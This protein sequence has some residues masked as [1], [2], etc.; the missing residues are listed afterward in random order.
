METPRDRSYRHTSHNSAS[1]K[2][3]GIS[4][5]AYG[6]LD[7]ATP[8]RSVSSHTHGSRKRKVGVP[9][10]REDGLYAQ[11]SH[12]EVEAELPVLTSS[13]SQAAFGNDIPNLVLS[14][15]D[16]TERT[17]VAA[18]DQS[19]MS[20]SAQG[21]GETGKKKRRRK[22]KI[23]FSS[24]D[25]S[26]NVRDDKSF[27]VNPTS[28]GGMTESQ[29]LTEDSDQTHTALFQKSTHGNDAVVSYEADRTVSSVGEV[30]SDLTLAM[31]PADVSMA[32]QTPT[33]A[34]RVLPLSERL[35]RRR[36]KKRKLI[37]SSPPLPRSDD[38]FAS[39]TPTR[40]RRSL[41]DVYENGMSPEKTSAQESDQGRTAETKPSEPASEKGTKT[42]RRKRRQP[43]ESDSTV[44]SRSQQEDADVDFA[45]PKKRK[46]SGS[47]RSHAANTLE[48]QVD[49]SLVSADAQIK[50]ITTTTPVP[51]ADNLTTLSPGRVQSLGERVTA[52]YH[53]ESVGSVSNDYD[54]QNEDSG[55]SPVT[56]AIVDASKDGEDAFPV[57][58]ENVDAV[59][60]SNSQLLPSDNGIHSPAKRA[61]PR[62][63]RSMLGIDGYD[64][65][66][67]TPKKTRKRAKTPGTAGNDDSIVFGSQHSVTMTTFDSILAANSPPR[68]LES[69]EVSSR[70][71]G[72]KAPTDFCVPESQSLD[73]R[74]PTVS[75]EHFVPESVG[76]DSQV[77][78]VSSNFCVPE[79]ES[80]D[81]QGA[82]GYLPTP[83]PGDLPD[84][85]SEAPSLFAAGGDQADITGTRV[86]SYGD[87]NH[88]SMKIKSPLKKPH[89]FTKKP[90]AVVGKN[91]SKSGMP[92]Q[93]A[94]LDS[95]GS[96][97][98]T[99]DEIVAGSEDDSSGTYNN[100]LSLPS[101]RYSLSQSAGAA[102]GSPKK[103]LRLSPPR[104]APIRCY[105]RRSSSPGQEIAAFQRV[106]AP[107]MKKTLPQ[108]TVALVS[109]CALHTANGHDS[110]E[111]VR[112]PVQSPASLMPHHR[113]PLS[114]P[115]SA[116]KKSP[117]RR[118]SLARLLSR[119]KPTNA[120]FAHGFDDELI[121]STPL[122]KISSS[123]TISTTEKA[124]ATT[125]KGHRKC[126]ASVSS[127]ATSPSSHL[128][129][130]TDL[131]EYSDTLPEELQP[132]LSSSFPGTPRLKEARSLPS[133]PTFPRSLSDLQTVDSPW[134][135]S[136][137]AYMFAVS[138]VPLGTGP[139]TSREVALLEANVKCYL[140]NEGLGRTAS[141]V[142]FDSTP[143][144]RRGFYATAGSGIR[145]SLISVYN[146][147]RSHY[148]PDIITGR[149]TKEE[150]VR[151][152]ELVATIGPKWHVIAHEMRRAPNPLLKKYQAL[153]EKEENQEESGKKKRKASYSRWSPEDTELLTAVVRELSGVHEGPVT[154][155]LHWTDVACQVPGKTASQ[156][157][158]RWTD[159]LASRGEPVVWSDMDRIKL[160][161]ALHAQ[162]SGVDGGIPW[163][164]IQS[165]YFPDVGTPSVK[166]LWNRVKSQVPRAGKKPLGEVLEALQKILP[167]S[168]S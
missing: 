50:L 160:V 156:C 134:D 148:R 82:G 112:T 142:I 46:K 3:L 34:I 98:D 88:V 21:S 161:A 6:F 117:A 96:G 79:S 26:E 64:D 30:T 113:E 102:S 107:V 105:G 109:D 93:G 37:S 133:T 17:V 66:E 16:V 83:I 40:R 72:A 115:H 152:L 100:P 120:P 104:A 167:S 87:T 18:R 163:D 51:G 2:S 136:E 97:I 129:T 141:E 125:K 78:M 137:T 145:R 58:M 32:E 52:G 55:M 111:N 44:A 67:A 60:A 166:R 122:S 75:G 31:S 150:E 157:R 153:C 130:D 49:E 84:S 70:R 92:L 63:S 128:A 164:G 77:S 45:S 86:P 38:G 85:D 42:R 103:R 116:T 95:S 90:R 27:V 165:R 13:D 146:F 143:K 123:P 9:K 147:M 65:I 57:T 22:R 138:G 155:P 61:R 20:P 19:L 108:C 28:L 43:S 35:K 158:K 149:F 14:P 144:K 114:S 76:L 99:L 23:S 89:S 54:G 139:W 159:E 126:K 127:G 62:Q 121:T 124:A 168:S 118:G 68:V 53:R 132:L 59:L 5:T 81:S 74:E 69:E 11:V 25:N 106:L 39:A 12:R 71:P 94:T 47:R 48:G 73:F 4:L 140:D 110:D 7:G 1:K 101:S 29:A 162:C 8:K 131:F 80:L 15:P 24:A 36:K 10:R 154:I 119:R 41:S 33:S 56:M 91:S 135:N 151:L